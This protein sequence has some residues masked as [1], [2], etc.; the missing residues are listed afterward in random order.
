MAPYI[1]LRYWE[2]FFYLSA[3]SKGHSKVK[4][5]SNCQ[6]NAIWLAKCVWVYVCTCMYMHTH[7]H[8][9]TDIPLWSSRFKSYS[10]VWL[11]IHRKDGISGTVGFPKSSVFC[12]SCYLCMTS[13][14]CL[15][16]N[17][18]KSSNVKVIADFILELLL[19]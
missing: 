2:K 4:C 1:N 15:R 3:Y 16:H 18:E 5:D 6:L 12:G 10:L 9:E 19:K 8:T 11:G 14:S 17:T 13:G 7:T